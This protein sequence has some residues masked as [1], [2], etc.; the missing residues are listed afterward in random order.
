MKNILIILVS[1]V[2]LFSCG[3]TNHH[4]INTVKEVKVYDNDVISIT[5]K[6]RHYDYQKVTIENHDFLFRTWR[7]KYGSGS[8]LVHSPNCKSCKKY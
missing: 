7:T 4:P 2:C 8:N 3:K 5:S 6:G 1:I